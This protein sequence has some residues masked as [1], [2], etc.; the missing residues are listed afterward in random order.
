V[1]IKL[2]FQ[3]I[4]FL[5]HP[6]NERSEKGR[7]HIEE[8]CE[9]VIK[10]LLTYSIS[11]RKFPVIHHNRLIRDQ[12]KLNRSQRLENLKNAYSFNGFTPDVGT[13]ILLDDVVTH[14]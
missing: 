2:N 4:S 1:R 14:G 10:K 9:V 11:A 5:F 6:L 3:L 12:S 7:N 13:T 8:L